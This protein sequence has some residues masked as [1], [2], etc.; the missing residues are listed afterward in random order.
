MPTSPEPL[1]PDLKYGGDDHWLKVQLDYAR[2]DVNA[3]TPS[4][5]ARAT[6]RF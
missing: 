1:Q 6:T 3:P 4:G 5:P 2:T